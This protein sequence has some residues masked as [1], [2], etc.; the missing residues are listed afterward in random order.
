MCK[1]V[2][3]TPGCILILFAQGERFS[4]LLLT[5]STQHT[6][7]Q[8]VYDQCHG[9]IPI[10]DLIK[11]RRFD[12]VLRRTPVSERVPLVVEAVNSFVTPTLSLCV[13]T[14]ALFIGVESRLA[15]CVSK[16]SDAVLCLQ[17]TD[18][19]TL[20]VREITNLFSDQ[21]LSLADEYHEYLQFITPLCLCVCFLIARALG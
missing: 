7:F 5:H 3:C 18:R 17:P 14:H 6:Q 16:G 8:S 11:I 10:S 20:I 1:W 13:L 21:S 12:F 19:S 15:Q 4:S 2:S 9:C